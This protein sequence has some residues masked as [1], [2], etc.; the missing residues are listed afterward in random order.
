MGTLSRLKFLDLYL[1]SYPGEFYRATY[2]ELLLEL[3]DLPNL[4][5]FKL[6]QISSPRRRL[7]DVIP[8][9]I[10]A[11]KGKSWP[12]LRHLEFRH[13][14]MTVADLVAFTLPHAGTLEVFR[15]Y[16]ELAC[17]SISE[18]AQEQNNR[19]YL[20]G[21]IRVEISPAQAFFDSFHVPH[22]QD[23]SNADDEEEL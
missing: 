23:P 19:T 22:H 14:V 13:W 10:G 3:H 1:N 21:W 11:L 12:R 16:G 5:T 18:T 2:L 6:A 8:N 15:L 7:T 17:S 20:E 9:I 4:D